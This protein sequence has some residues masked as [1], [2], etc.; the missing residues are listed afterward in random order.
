MCSL[1]QD[2]D[3]MPIAITAKEKQ[4]R[5]ILLTR[6]FALG[7]VI[8]DR[9]RWVYFLPLGY[10]KFSQQDRDTIQDALRILQVS[11]YL[12]YQSPKCYAENISA[13]AHYYHNIELPCPG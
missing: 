4:L 11:P 3:N 1:I 8:N 6:G 9:H 2:P 7:S 5:Q 10:S 12:Y 13:Y